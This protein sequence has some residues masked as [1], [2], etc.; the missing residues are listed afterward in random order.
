VRERGGGG[1]FA[2]GTSFLLQKPGAPSPY[3]TSGEVRVWHD[4]IGFRRND[5]ILVVVDAGP[6]HAF[7]TL[8]D[9]E[10]VLF[11]VPFGASNFDLAG[12]FVA[13][14]AAGAPAGLQVWLAD[15]GAGT[16]RPVSHHYSA[17]QHLTVEPSGR[18]LWDDTVFS[19]RAVFV[20]AP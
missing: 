11:P 1:T 8:D 14:V 17:K 12:D 20:S 7:N 16:R 5:G 9:V 6:D 4:R 15:I 10:Q 2:G 18:V 13:Y 19:D 3:L